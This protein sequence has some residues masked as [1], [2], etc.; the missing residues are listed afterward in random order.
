MTRLNGII[1]KPVKNWCCEIFPLKDV[2]FDPP[3]HNSTD[4]IFHVGPRWDGE[5][6]IKFFEGAFL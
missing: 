4:L 2:P 1:F 5:H 6:I 3:R